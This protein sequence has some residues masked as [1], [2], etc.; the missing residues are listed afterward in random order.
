M[1]CDPSVRA[2][3]ILEIDLGAIVANYRL[4]AKKA[5]PASCAAVVKA[6]AYGL[7]AAPV[8]RALLAAGCKRFF[9]G[10]LDEGI[11]L[12]SAFGPAPKIAVFNGPLPGSAAE[13]AAA[14]LTPVLNDPGQIEAWASLTAGSKPPPLVHVDTGLARLGLSPAELDASFDR[15]R[16]VGAI[17]LIS[18][19]ACADSPAHTL[20]I[21]QR[22]RFLA[23]RQR[24]PGLSASLAASS[25]IFL[26]PNFHFDE[27]RPGAALY[28]VNPLPGCPNPMRPV[29]RLAAKIVQIRKIDSGE[30]VGYGAA[31]VMDGPGLLATAS[32][33]YADGWPRSLSHR[34]CGWIAGKRAPLLGR[35]SMD[36]ATFDVS[37]VAPSEL[38]PG[39]MIE[40][41]GERYSVDDAAADAGT[42]G[43]EILTALGAR[44]HRIYREPQE[45]ALTE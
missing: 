11:A 6:N 26:G 15:I 41:I 8:A 21:M 13:F 7:G 1:S 45:S 30:S 24:L 32:I 42:I 23:A 40:L 36:L 44:Y 9:V 14:K 2:G 37:A 18:H 25:G 17:G 22:E 3:A 33:G 28:G 43:Y 35:M 20:N 38:Y 29:V 5:A 10:T 34:G 39:N 4:L 27:V 16:A 19:L 12:R 31:H